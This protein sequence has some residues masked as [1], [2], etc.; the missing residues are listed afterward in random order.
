MSLDPE[1]MLS[2]LCHYTVIHDSKYKNWERFVHRLSEQSKAM[3][4]E[5][6]KVVSP[7]V[8]KKLKKP[9]TIASLSDPVI[10]LLSGKLLVPLIHS[11]NPGPEDYLTRDEIWGIKLG[12]LTALRIEPSDSWPLVSE[13]VMRASGIDPENPDLTGLAYELGRRWASLKGD[14]PIKR[15]LAMGFYSSTPI[16][17]RVIADVVCKDKDEDFFKDL[18]L[19][20]GAAR[21]VRAL[22]EIKEPEMRKKAQAL[23]KV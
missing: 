6:E 20:Y 7:S 1:Q 11:P 16:E 13:I 8:L 5:G 2:S 9:S 12:F 3:A 22:D 18:W 19:V 17:W 10:N 23:L 4:K 21:G 15:A 14:S